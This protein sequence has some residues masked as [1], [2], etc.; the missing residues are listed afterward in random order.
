MAPSQLIETDDRM[1]VD[2]YVV[3]VRDSVHEAVTG[4]PA[5]TY[6]SPPQPYQQALTLATALLGHQPPDAPT[7]HSSCRW[8]SATPGGRR[9]VTLQRYAG[10]RREPDTR[11]TFPEASAPE[12]ACV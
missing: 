6:A 1:A 10:A 2:T 4:R 3:C 5:I 8:T 9:I 11:A 7:A 12:R